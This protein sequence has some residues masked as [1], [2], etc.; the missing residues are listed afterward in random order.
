MADHIEDVP[1]QRGT[2]SGEI[3]QN[4][5]EIRQ[6]VPPPKEKPASGH[7]P[8]TEEPVSEPRDRGLF[9]QN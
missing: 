7:R 6:P 5:V 2:S 8:D 4:P 1:T 3:G 9:E